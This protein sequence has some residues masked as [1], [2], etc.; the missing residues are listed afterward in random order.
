[1]IEQSDRTEYPVEAVL[2]CQGCGYINPATEELCLACAATLEANRRER[3]T[4]RY[5]HVRKHVEALRAG[6]LSHDD[7][8]YWLD[9]LLTEMLER[10]RGI[11]AFMQES[12]YWK[13]NQ[14]EV[15]TGLKGVESFE[16]GLYEIATYF[17][18]LNEA[19][20]DEGLQLCWA[21]TEKIVDA[22][23]I[24]RQNRESLSLDWEVSYDDYEEVSA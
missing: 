19:H 10:G 22:M 18:D 8:R 11:L 16:A 3:F 21:G 15:E 2:A 4:G 20:L 17:E 12:E 6:E 24:N 14:E 9:E 23:R 5:N 13:E 1:M 7:F